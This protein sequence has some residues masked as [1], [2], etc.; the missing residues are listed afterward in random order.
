MISKGCSYVCAGLLCMSFSG[1]GGS[2]I[3]WVW[4]ELVTL[5]GSIICGREFDGSDVVGVYGISLMRGSL[6]TGRVAPYLKCISTTFK[7]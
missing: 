4:V 7:A 3:I 2:T 6:G 1:K 5:V